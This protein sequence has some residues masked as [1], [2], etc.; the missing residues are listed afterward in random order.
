M[1]KVP[2]SRAEVLILLLV[3]LVVTA[4][5]A[6]GMRA[7]QNRDNRWVRIV[8]PSGEKAVEIVVVT[9]LLQ[10]YVRTEQGGFYFCTGSAWNDTCRQVDV[11]RVPSNP[12]P[13]R[14]LSCPPELPRLPAL[15]GE[16]V[17]ALEVGQCQEGRTYSKLVILDDGSIW[18]WKRTFSWVNGFALGSVIAYGILFGALLGVAV[19]YVRR[20]L[21]KPIP[22]V[23]T[24][25]KPGK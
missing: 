22:P 24:G 2:Y 18:Q 19:V 15:P 23:N 9:R 6:L 12:V 13:A 1:K 21:L 20:G 3:T 17:H 4:L 25:P 7:Y 16:V 8:S 14:W 5:A 11:T 10:P